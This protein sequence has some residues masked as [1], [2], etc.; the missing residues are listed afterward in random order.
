MNLLDANPRQQTLGIGTHHESSIE[1]SHLHRSRDG[2][3]VTRLYH[4]RAVAIDDPAGR[5]SCY[6]P[7][8]MNFY[9]TL[10]CDP[11]NGSTSAGDIV[12]S[13]KNGQRN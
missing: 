11:T 1:K 13:Q 8:G 9:E 5:R 12:R 4:V 7:I 10:N 2:G 3:E 6:P